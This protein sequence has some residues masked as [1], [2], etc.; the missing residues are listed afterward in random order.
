MASLKTPNQFE[1]TL[2]LKLAGPLIKV[3][4]K[5]LNLAKLF[6]ETVKDKELEN[7]KHFLRKIRF[8]IENTNAKSFLI[9]SPKTGEGKSF[10]IFSLAF[11][12]SIVKRKV[13]IIDTNF[14]NNTL[15]RWLAE[16]R[17]DIKKY[18]IDVRKFKK[19][20]RC[21]TRKSLNFDT[22]FL[23]YKTKMAKLALFFVKI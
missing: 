5:K 9:T 12:L 13:L 14:K 10:I 22:K 1:R 16:K 11:V 15:T 23:G 8:E 3:D 17:K 20:L 18:N 7:F 2:D 21:K 4:I 6:S 19:F